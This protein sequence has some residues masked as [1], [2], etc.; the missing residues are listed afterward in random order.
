MLSS[1][2]VITLAPTST[3]LGG[4]RR[5]SQFFRQI[6]SSCLEIARTVIACGGLMPIAAAAEIATLMDPVKDE[7]I[8]HGIRPDLGA[9]DLWIV[10]R[11]HLA[12]SP[13]P[14]GWRDVGGV[15]SAT[16]QMVS[17]FAWRPKVACFSGHTLDSFGDP[18]WSGECG[19]GTSRCPGADGERASD[20]VDSR[21]LRRGHDHRLSAMADRSLPLAADFVPSQR[22]ILNNLGEG[23]K[24]AGGYL[25]MG[26]S[27]HS[28]NSGLPASI[29]CHA[30]C[31][32]LF[33]CETVEQSSSASSIIFL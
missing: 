12:I 26:L 20:T 10:P 17:A 14:S 24:A 29:L 21:K 3:T 33:S 23:A 11:G 8:S 2:V 18:Y 32:V 9:A 16:L 25:V 27:F 4:Y 7:E 19:V 1:A 5:G 22:E 15:V 13:G 31:H 6:G 28:G 30:L